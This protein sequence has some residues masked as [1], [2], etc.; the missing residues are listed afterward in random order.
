MTTNNGKPPIVE[1]EPVHELY[2]SLVGKSDSSREYAVRRSRSWGTA[3]DAADHRK[4]EADAR[5]TL[6]RQQSHTGNRHDGATLIPSDEGRYYSEPSSSSQFIKFYRKSSCEQSRRT[7]SD[8]GSGAQTQKQEEFS[9]SSRAASI[10]KSKQQAQ[11]DINNK[12][13]YHPSKERTT[14]S[15][16]R[17]IARCEHERQIRKDKRIRMMLRSDFSEEDEMLYRGLHR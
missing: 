17:R 6:R 8:R 3:A 5:S 9:P 1:D 7:S 16:R 2:A 11:N 12:F 4:R 13:R 14:K 10:H 15:E